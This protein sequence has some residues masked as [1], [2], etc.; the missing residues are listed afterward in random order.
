VPRTLLDVARG[1]NRRI[2]ER[3]CDQAEVLGVLDIDAIRELLG[4]MA[5]SRGAGRL[6]AVLELGQVGESLPRSELEARFLALCRRA[7]LPPPSVNAWIPVP[8]EEL[9]GDFAWFGQQVIVETDGFSAHGTRQAFRRDRRRDRILSLAGWQVVRFT[10]DEVTNEPGQV[11][12]VVRKLL[13]GR[14]KQRPSAP[15]PHEGR[16]ALVYRAQFGLRRV[17][18]L[19]GVVGAR[20]VVGP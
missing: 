14:T 2:L 10:W 5:R 12:E 9:Q 13:A 17:F 1:A 16:I 6:R 18:G 11:T 20:E 8:G 4:R 3:A 19:R 7:G 15:W